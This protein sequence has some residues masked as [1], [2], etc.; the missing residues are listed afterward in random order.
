M[1][2]AERLKAFAERLA[3]LV[4][5]GRITAEDAREACANLRFMLESVD[6]VCPTEDDDD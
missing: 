5:G 6:L 4:V 3:P 1:T 2:I